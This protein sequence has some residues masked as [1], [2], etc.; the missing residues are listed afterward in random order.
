MLSICISMPTPWQQLRADFYHL[1]GEVVPNVMR[2]I[3]ERE[4]NVA[5]G[6]NA[7]QAIPDQ[8]NNVRGV[9]GRNEVHF[10]RKANLK[11]HI[12]RKEQAHKELYDSSSLILMMSCKFVIYYSSHDTVEFDD[13]VCTLQ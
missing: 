5:A 12:T 8:V 9:P 7:E 11:Q 13:S 1:N 10:G 6:P 3:L 4:R 2:V